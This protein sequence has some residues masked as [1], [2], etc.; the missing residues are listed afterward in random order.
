VI[1][2]IDRD[3]MR[4]DFLSLLYFTDDVIMIFNIEE[5]AARLSD[6]IY[7]QCATIFCRL[8]NI[9]SAHLFVEDSNS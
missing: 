2:D 8:Q 9:I 5:I 4:L 1:N 3:F 6:V 7:Y